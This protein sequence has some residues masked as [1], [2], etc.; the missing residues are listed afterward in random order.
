MI[1]TTGG[2]MK[3]TTLL[4]LGALL[5]LSTHMKAEKATY[6]DTTASVE[7]RVEDLLL[8]MTLEEKILMLAGDPK[9]HFDTRPIERL[10]IPRF[11][12]ADGP[13]GIRGDEATCFP[14]SIAMAATWNESLM[15]RVG[16][17]IAEEAL[18][19]GRNVLLGPCINIHRQPFGGRNFESFSED[20]YLCARITVG[21]VKGVQ[22]RGVICTPKHFAANNQE[23]ERKSISVEVD[24]RALHEIYFPAFKAAVE[25]GG[26]WSVMAAYNKVNGVYA[27]ENDF[28]LNQVLKKDWGFKGFVMSDWVSVFSAER[29]ALGGLDMEMPYGE[30]FSDKLLQAVKEGKVFPFDDNLVSRPGPRL[31]DGLEAM[32]RLLHPQ[33]FP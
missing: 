19:K 4:L 20:P 16:A 33:Q 14:T 11:S 18:G 22:S 7:N 9:T 1:Y 24:V 6:Q 3:R 15:E 25:E 27:S 23:Y 12:M 26:A 21:Y 32:A 31:V 28:L 10:G 30:Y 2:Y 29:A 13:H 8:R 17:A 5:L